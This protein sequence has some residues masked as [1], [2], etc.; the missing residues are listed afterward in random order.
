M[1]A[2]VN[3]TN[4]CSLGCF[5]RETVTTTKTGYS[6]ESD[7]SLLFEI[8]INQVRLFYTSFQKN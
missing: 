4:K 3:F 6:M 7:Y 8:Q 2:F 1:K 5:Y